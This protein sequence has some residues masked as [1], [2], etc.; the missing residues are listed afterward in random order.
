MRVPDLAAGTGQVPGWFVPLGLTVVAVEPD[1]Q[2]RTVLA[3]RFPDNN[4]RA[5]AADAGFRPQD[6]WSYSQP[7]VTVGSV[8]A[9]GRAEQAA[10]GPKAARR[11]R[12]MAGCTVNMA[13]ARSGHVAT[14]FRAATGI[15]PCPVQSFVVPLP[16]GVWAMEARRRSFSSLSLS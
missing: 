15:G 1:Q 6:S 9:P 14:V 8:A 7:Q 3:A 13:S 10:T 16:A 11:A 2:M 5:L 12:I 4:R